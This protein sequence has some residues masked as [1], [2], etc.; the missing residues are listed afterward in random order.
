MLSR[1]VKRLRRGKCGRVTDF[2][3]GCL[4]FACTYLQCSLGDGVAEQVNPLLLTGCKLCRPSA[5][6]AKFGHPARKRT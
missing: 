5:S 1:L 2:R 4:P 6:C 3:A